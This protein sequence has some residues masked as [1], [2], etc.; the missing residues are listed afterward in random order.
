MRISL[1]NTQIKMFTKQSKSAPY[2]FPTPTR[3]TNTW[4]DTLTQNFSPIKYSQ[5][6]S[7]PNSLAHDT[8]PNTSQ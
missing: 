1:F 8:G 4:K 7:N 3:A 2:T 5:K 6:N